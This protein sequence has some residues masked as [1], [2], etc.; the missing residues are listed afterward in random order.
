MIKLP[1]T[2]AIPDDFHG[3]YDGELALA[4]VQ[5][6]KLNHS[7]GS[8]EAYK[9]WRRDG[10]IIR[11]ARDHDCYRKPLAITFETAVV[12][13][14]I[15]EGICFAKTKKTWGR[16]LSFRKMHSKELEYIEKALP[17][18]N[19]LCY[20]LRDSNPIKQKQITRNEYKLLLGKYQHELVNRAMKLNLKK[21][22]RTGCAF[23]ETLVP[24]EK[25]TFK[26]LGITPGEFW[27]DIR[28]GNI[29]RVRKMAKPDKRRNCQLKHYLHDFDE[30][31][32][33]VTF[34]LDLCKEVI[35]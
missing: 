4:W 20:I 19:R 13:G 17:E 3:K 16:P 5:A 24:S 8:D 30:K 1:K 21:P 32:D 26:D 22:S 31:P 9:Q 2:Y 23:L 28:N 34:G 18:Q 27:Q 33:P 7:F 15:N 11:Y 25:K 10:A 14:Q 12:Y 35:F 29:N 6:K